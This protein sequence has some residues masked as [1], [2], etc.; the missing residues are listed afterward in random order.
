MASRNRNFASIL[1]EES[2]LA[3]WQAILVEHFVPCFISPLHMNDTD[4]NGNL[5]KPHYHIMIMFD[6]VKT[7]EQ[8]KEIFDSIGAVG[9]EVVKSLRGYARYLCHLDNPE[10][11]QYNPEEVLSFCGSDYMGVIGMALDKYKAIGEM[12]EF[13][14]NNCIYNYA[15]LLNYCRQ[16]RFDWF[17]VLCDSGTYVIKEYLKSAEFINYEKSCD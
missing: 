3:N 11:A 4:I 15:E 1:Y 8:A 7:N 9:C 6:G 14:E 17:R 2:A 5:K 16:S 13:C 10:K 12:I